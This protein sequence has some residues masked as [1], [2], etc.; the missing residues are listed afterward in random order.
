MKMSKTLMMLF[1]AVGMLANFAIAQN[2]Y[3]GTKMCKACHNTEKMGKQFDV[4]PLV[5][6]CRRL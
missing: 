3:V 6:C 2:K 5:P 1:L 4:Q